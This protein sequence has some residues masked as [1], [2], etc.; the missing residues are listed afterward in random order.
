MNWTNLGVSLAKL[1][2]PMLASVFLG[3]EAGPLVGALITKLAGAFGVDATPEAVQTA[4]TTDP[5]AGTKV[6]AVE[7]QHADIVEAYLADVAN[8]RAANVQ[9]VQTGSAIA[10]AAP[11]VSMIAIVGFLTIAAYL[12]VV[13]DMNVRIT[14]LAA[15]IAGWTTVLNFYLGSSKGSADSSAEVRSML[16][17][18][19]T[20][21]VPTSNVAKRANR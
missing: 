8:A 18:T 2:A 7:A 12:S 1:G 17:Q 14:I 15:M 3:P 20:T 21:G 9:L 13:G 10:W 5:D 4:I 6:Q 11:V 19:I 16:R